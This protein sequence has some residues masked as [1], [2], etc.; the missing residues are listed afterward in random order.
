M[1][2]LQLFG[3]PVK[4]LKIGHNKRKNVKK[5]KSIIIDLNYTNNIKTIV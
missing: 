1:G 3:G 5:L 2:R 4:L